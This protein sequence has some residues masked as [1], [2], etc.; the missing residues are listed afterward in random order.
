MTSQVSA[1]IN[2]NDLDGEGLLYVWEAN[3]MGINNDGITDLDLP[4]QGTYPLHKDI[5][6]E[7]DYMELHRPNSDAID[8]LITDIFKS[9]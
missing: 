8:N 1:P 7:I 4:S 2:R 3:E 6:V 9:V 5:F